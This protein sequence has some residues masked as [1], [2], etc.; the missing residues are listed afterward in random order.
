MDFEKAEAVDERELK[1]HRGPL[2]PVEA[3]GNEFIAIGDQSE[4]I[5]KPLV[6]SL[7]RIPNDRQSISKSSL[8]KAIKSDLPKLAE[9]LPVSLGNL[10]WH[11]HHASSRI[12]DLS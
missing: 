8:A 3:S 9:D 12:T 2:R 10:G 11:R 1:K 4:Q 5:K 7:G 6:V